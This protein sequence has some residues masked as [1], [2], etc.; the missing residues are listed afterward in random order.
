MDKGHSGRVAGALG[1]VLI[2]LVTV[3]VLSVG[4]FA[5]YRVGQLNPFICDGPCGAQYVVP[6]K[7]LGVTVEQ[8]KV[9]P[10]SP[11]AGPAQAAR[12]A[13]AVRATLTRPALG[14]RVGFVAVDPD[15][16]T[17][18]TESGKGTFTPAS[19]TKVLT[20]FAALE[21]LDAGTRFATRVVQTKPGSLVLVGGGDPLLTTKKPK[22][23]LYA[24]RANLTDLARKTAAALKT[25]GTT[26]VSL[27]FD[28]SLFTGPEVSSHWE[29]SYVP[30]NIVTPITALWADEGVSN[31]LR[32]RTP[33]ASAAATFASLLGNNGIDVNG[34]SPRVKAPS[35]ATGV[36]RVDSAPVGHILESLIQRSDNQAAEVMLR[37]VA[38]AEGR[39][40][41]FDEGTAA[42]KR[43]L[44]AAGVDI[45]GLELYDGSGLSRDNLISPLTLAQ[46]MHA[47]ANSPRA[48]SLMSALPIAGFNGS[49]LDRFQG[50]T[51]KDGRGVVHA[52]TG[53]LTTVYSLVGFVSDADGRA[54]IISIMADR[55]GTASP[56]AVKA[57]LD[58]VAAALA[59]CHCGD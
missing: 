47:A 2:P 55:T 28:D 46:T 17:T 50:S 6:P 8:Q 59:R 21:S 30:G 11:T 31:G 18:L 48:E 15:T 14:K 38:V 26:T 34:S 33:A 54:I 25:S 41:T 58:D 57:A 22:P 27:G 32:S 29:R 12:V 36:A 56:L 9:G 39:P 16:G 49:L 10:D 23:A 43:L 1:A 45:G 19:T 51:S 35:G 42:V 44:K 24:H 37:H 13:S 4:A 52:K 7:A 20:A 40:G 5:T 53:T 3:V